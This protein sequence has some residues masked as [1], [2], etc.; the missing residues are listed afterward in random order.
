MLCVAAGT[1]WAVYLTI[2]MVRKQWGPRI[3][4]LTASL[5]MLA[6]PGDIGASKLETIPIG[7]LSVVGSF[8][9]FGLGTAAALMRHRW[10]KSDS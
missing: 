3:I 1:V 2:G 5:V 4:P 6:G 7:M 10:H 9:L 8:L